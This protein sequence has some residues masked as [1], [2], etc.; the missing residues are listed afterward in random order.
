M[1]I[2]GRILAEVDMTA[3]VN[4]MVP[5]ETDRIFYDRD[6]ITSLGNLHAIGADP[7]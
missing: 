4:P 1:S 6:P 2:K 5:D 3:L 7:I